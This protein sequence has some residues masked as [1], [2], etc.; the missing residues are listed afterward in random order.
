[1]KN[2]DIKFLVC[3]VHEKETKLDV[4]LEMTFD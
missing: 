4:I 1:M 2:L 3:D